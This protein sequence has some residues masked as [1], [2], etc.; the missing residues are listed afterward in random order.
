MSL[1]PVIS[2]TPRPPRLRVELVPSTCSFSNVR[3]FLSAHRWRNLS[4]EVAEL[5]GDRC[6]VCR[7]RG[8]R[9]AV[10]CH[11]VWLYDDDTRVQTLLRL[12]ALCPMCHAI[13]HLG[14]AIRLNG[15]ERALNWLA[16]VNGWNAATTAWYADAVFKQW[17]QRSRVE[18]TLDVTVLGE[19]YEIPLESLGLRSYVLDPRERQQMQHGRGPTLEDIYQRDGSSP[20]D[21]RLRSNKDD[22][23]KGI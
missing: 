21:S 7:G 23:R 8:R 3:S 4:W 6:E 5:G 15:Q 16:K 14:R 2:P 9:H 11:E 22:L 20:A 10:D 13:K 17:V 18:W 1:A 19:L 12:Q